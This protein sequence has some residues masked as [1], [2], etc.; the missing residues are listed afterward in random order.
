LCIVDADE[1]KPRVL[2]RKSSSFY[3]QQLERDARWA[4]M[5]TSGAS[6]QAS[7]AESEE[8]SDE[9]EVSEFSADKM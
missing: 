1:S 7:I 8:S 6:K 5:A 3:V 4:K 2:L 9:G